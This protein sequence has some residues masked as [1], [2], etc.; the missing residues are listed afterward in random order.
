MAKFEYTYNSLDA[1]V[2]HLT[3]DDIFNITLI[4]RET[5]IEIDVLDDGDTCLG[6]LFIENP[7]REE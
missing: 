1:E 2:A 5:G 6:G 7:S 3:I 4:R